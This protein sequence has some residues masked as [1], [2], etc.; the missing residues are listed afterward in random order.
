MHKHSTYKYMVNG[1]LN[2]FAKRF[3]CVK[4]VC[5]DHMCCVFFHMFVSL[6]TTWIKTTR[7]IEIAFTMSKK[8]MF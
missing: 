8:N 1:S 3:V 6:Q 4:Q 2:V 7:F 5:F